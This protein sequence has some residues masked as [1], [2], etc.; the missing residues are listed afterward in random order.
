MDRSLVRMLENKPETESLMR[1]LTTHKRGRGGSFWLLQLPSWRG[2]ESLNLIIK[3]CA[4]QSPQTLSPTYPQFPALHFHVALLDDVIKI[5]SHS[6][7]C[8]SQ[9]PLPRADGFARLSHLLAVQLPPSPHTPPSSGVH[10]F[11]GTPRHPGP[12][13]S[14]P[15]APP[16]CSSSPHAHLL[17]GSLPGAGCKIKVTDRER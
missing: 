12:L 2:S 13:T 9:E 7:A 11:L 8:R 4:S 17:P 14:P 10:L 16:H 5:C 6:V 3:N 15:P 1:M